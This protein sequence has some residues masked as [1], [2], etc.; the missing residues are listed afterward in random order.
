MTNER[1]FVEVKRTLDGKVVR[2]PAQPLLVESGVRAVILC[3]IDEPEVVAGGRI[4]LEQ[5]TLSLGYFWFERPYNVYHWLYG[6]KTLMHY[7]N[8]GRFHSLNDSS[9]VWDDYAVDVLAHPDGRV[10]V[11]DEDEIPQTVD[12]AT[13]ELIADATAA[14]LRDLDALVV[15]VENETRELLV[16]HPQRRA[17]LN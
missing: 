15:E 6:G 9:L 8:I 17:L 14:V 7:I 16:A 4:T 13:R 12:S 5:G 10:E 3:S 11:I 1:R 2:Y